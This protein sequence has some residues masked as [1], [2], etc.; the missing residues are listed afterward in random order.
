MTKVISIHNAIF[1]T[2]IGC[3]LVLNDVRHVLDVRLDIVSTG[4]LDDEGYPNH[5]S[6][7][8]WMLTK[9]SPTIA[10]YWKLNSLYLMHVMF[11]I[12]VWISSL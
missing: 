12:F 5:F 9:G 2:D 1:M 3:K 6:I 7:R 11:R 8:R 10:K 4:K